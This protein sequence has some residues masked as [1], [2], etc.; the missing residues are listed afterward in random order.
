MDQ[1]LKTKQKTEKFKLF[2]IPMVDQSQTGLSLP[3]PTA[4]SCGGFVLNKKYT[5]S[6][7]DL[8]VCGMETFIRPANACGDRITNLSNWFIKNK[9]R[10]SE[11]YVNITLSKGHSL[12]TKPISE[13]KRLLTMS[14]PS[15]LTTVLKKNA[16]FTFR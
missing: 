2:M 4:A 10:I 15:N 9:N 8:S 1:S 5:Y 14:Q 13:W 7:I 11:S 3:P 16:P 12:Y 6:P